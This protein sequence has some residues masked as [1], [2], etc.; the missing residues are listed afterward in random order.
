MLVGRESELD[1]LARLT[2]AGGAVVLVGDAGIGK[3]AL[4]RELRD[5]AQAR[6]LSTTGVPTESDLAFGGIAELLGPVAAQVLDLGGP[7]G[8]A[9]ASALA[10]GPASPGDRLAVAVGTLDVLRA[11]APVLVLVDD[12][13]W[14]DAASR[15]CLL[16][17]AR[18]CGDDG[19]TVVASARP[20]TLPEGH[21]VRES[22]VEPLSPEAAR[23]LLDDPDAARADGIIALARGNPLA[24]R[25]LPKA[26]ADQP[27]GLPGLPVDPGEQVSACFAQRIDRLSAGATKGLVLVA[28]S[29]DGRLSD[30]T[31][32]YAAEGL[33]QADLDEAEAA[34]L[35]VIDGD[36]VRFEHPLVQSAVYHRATAG[37]RRRAHG[38]LGQ[39]IDGQAAVWHRSAAAT[40]PDE[41]IAAGLDTLA[42]EAHSRRGYHLA[43]T[44]YERAAR[45][46][47]EDFGVCMRLLAAGAEALAA[48]EAQRA[49]TLAEEATRRAPDPMLA[50][51][52]EHLA[53]V[54]DMW[55]VDAGR[56]E[57]RLRAAAERFA[58]D[59]PHQSAAMLAD[60]SLA[61][62]SNGDC[63]QAL[64]NARRAHELAADAPA[65][66]RAHA[67]TALAWALLLTGA[68]DE[69]VALYHRIEPLLTEVDPLS[70]AAQ[71]IGLALNIRSQTADLRAARAEAL[72][73][74]EG[75]ELAGALSGVAFPLGV[76]CESALRLGEW[77]GLES[78]YERA[79]VLAG[80]T[81]QAPPLAFLL[82]SR[83]RLRAAR[84]EARGARPTWRTPAPSRGRW[85]CT[86]S[87]PMPSV[88]WGCWPWASASSSRPRPCSSTCAR[89]SAAMVNAT[90]PSCHGR[91]S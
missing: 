62:T 23:R 10:L 47:S 24:L 56:A 50:A 48:G 15:E 82:V 87:R 72:A 5:R 52:G 45:L 8:E 85:A 22:V 79:V 42:A 39:V 19:V 69:G 20:G 74:S 18:R 7:R 71:S 13:Q 43:S 2:A 3:T 66:V 58:S 55:H 68:H 64:R 26:L 21:G 38:A 86:A 17:V 53:G 63:R 41:E 91:P 1:E 14:L 84:G 32:A 9:L 6:V 25:E 70:P 4:L 31:R 28:A 29:H 33:T 46:S 80:E 61:A 60:A 78:D 77:D 27:V 89:S 75:A 54:I 83:A 11:V 57:R 34:E 36:R 51:G 90:P 76:A 40:A 88:R 73:L 35:V 59:V 49:A 12:L 81:R 37:E 44:A 16:A 65:P 67:G 30:L